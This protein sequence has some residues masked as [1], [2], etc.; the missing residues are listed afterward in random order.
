MTTWTH[1]LTRP[2]TGLHAALDID[3]DDATAPSPT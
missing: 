3:A 2:G 1:A